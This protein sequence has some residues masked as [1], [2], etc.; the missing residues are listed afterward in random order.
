[1]AKKI[2]PLLQEAVAALKEMLLLH[3]DM[4]TNISRMAIQNYQRMNDAPL[5]AQVV[6]AKVEGAK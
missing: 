6:I 2:D 5:A 1:M 3:E 4:M